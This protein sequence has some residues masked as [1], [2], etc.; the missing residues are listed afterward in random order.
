MSRT[1]S[2]NARHVQRTTT[3]GERWPSMNNSPKKMLPSSAAKEICS[4]INHPRHNVSRYSHAFDQSVCVPSTA[5]TVVHNQPN[6][7]TNREGDEDIGDQRAARHL[8]E[9]ERDTG[10]FEEFFLL[11]QIT[12]AEFSE[13]VLLAEL[14]EKRV[15]LA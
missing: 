9:D 2:R 14:V 12:F 7:T 5:N 10:G 6:S 8:A 11:L 4:V 15:Y 13:A 3:S 1:N